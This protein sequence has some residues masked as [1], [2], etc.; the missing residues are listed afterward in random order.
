MADLP[1]TIVPAL[2]QA[3][4]H[5]LWQGA[6]IGLFAALLL[7]LLRDA[8]PQARYAVACVALLACVLAPLATLLAPLAAPSLAPIGTLAAPDGVASGYRHSL[9]ALVTP[10]TG[11]ATWHPWIVALWAA[12]TSVL[13]LRLVLGLAWIHRLRHAPQAAANPAWQARLDALAAHFGLR[14][15]VVLRLVDDLDSPVSAGWLRPVVLLPTALLTRMP[16][17]LIEALLAHELAHIRRHDYLVNLLQNA[18][19]A[20]L[21]YHPVTWWLSRRIRIEREQIADQ[22]AAEVACAPRRLALALSEL[23]EL[24]RAQPALHLVQAAHGGQLMTRIERLLRPARTA[25]PA[26]RLVFPLLGLIAAGVATYSYARIGEPLDA[27]SALEAGPAQPAPHDAPRVDGFALVRKHGKDITMWGQS[28]QESIDAVRRAGDGE[29][30]WFRR[31]GR[32]W[33]VTDPALLARVRDAWREMETL[34][35]RMDPLSE[36]M[37]EHS[38]KLDALSEK[39]GRLAD[40]NEPTAAMEAA[41]AEMERLGE[42][43]DALGQKQEALSD[44]QSELDGSDEAA[45]AK[46]EAEQEALAAQQDQLARL[47]QRQSAIM[48]AEQM[49]ME[50][51]QQ[52]MEALSREMERASQPMEALSEQMEAHSREIDK[53]AQRAEQATR[54]LIDEAMRR[55]LAQPAPRGD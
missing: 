29:F 55:K 1:A 17:D 44:R 10:A 23:S 6:L 38:R 22:L 40:A 26:A 14:R 32:L 28:D 13:S 27:T 46:L 50:A 47:Q 24:E 39:M 18:V 35:A 37:D 34:S 19:E 45:L 16:V 54:V 43:Q 33:F 51:N 9:L 12:G 30:L 48:E 5:F 15:A 36:K 42:Q 11:F 2:G 52:P 49:R 7:H 4:L 25:H 8:R 3:L 20:L 41:E 31:D 21:F 53:A